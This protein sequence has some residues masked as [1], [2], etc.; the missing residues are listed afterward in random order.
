M[1]KLKILNSREVRN[2][3][4]ILLE[5][6]GYCFEGDFAF[7]Q[8]EKDRLFVVNKDVAR[9]PL[10]H[11]KIDK[12]GLYFAE[13][14]EA[15]LRLSKEGAIFLER[16]ARQ[17]KKVVGPI[18]ELTEV[19]VKEY[20]GG[21]DLARELQL[22]KKFILLSYKESI[23]GCSAYKEGRILNYLPKIHRGEVII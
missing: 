20:F 8:N 23:L 17:D 21:K 7:L 12:M 22:D 19:E 2:V 13:M 9:L 6:F 5:Q 16:C 3:K 11:L 14:K 15:S 1:Q 10:E 18:V 4:E